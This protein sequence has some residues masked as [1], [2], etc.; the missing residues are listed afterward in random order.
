LLVTSAFHIPISM[1]IFRLRGW[2]VIAYPV[3]YYS[4][5]AYGLR[6]DAI[7]WM[8]VRDLN[9]TLKEW[10]GLFVYYYSGKTDAL[11]PGPD[12]LGIVP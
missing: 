6:L 1:G 2:N 11:F 5:T 12:E 10:I 7:Y 8:H 3:D 9:F 4:K